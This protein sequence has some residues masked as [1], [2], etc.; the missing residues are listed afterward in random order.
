MFQRRL[1]LL[2]PIGGL[3]VLALV[4]ILIS[5]WQSF[6]TSKPEPATSKR[7]VIE[8]PPDQ[9]YGGTSSGSQL[10]ISPDGKTIV[11]LARGQGNR[12]LYVKNI[13]DD[14]PATPIPGTER[15]TEPT[16]S[17]MGEQIAFVSN[18]RIKTVSAQGGPVRDAGEAP[19]IRG[20]SWLSDDELVLGNGRGGLLRFKLS[21]GISSALRKSDGEFGP[22]TP[23]Y[24]PHVLPG[25]KAV[26]FTAIDGFGLRSA[27]TRVL[28]LETGEVRTVISDSGYW[29]RYA[30]SG[31]IVYASE[32]PHVAMA[33]HFDLD[34]LKVIGLP[35]RIIDIDLG[36]GYAGG[37]D[38]VFSASGVMVYAPRSPSDVDELISNLGGF[39]LSQIHVVR[40]WFED[41]TQKLGPA[42]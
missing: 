3:V 41:L 37:T 38:F 9:A 6:M 21:E 11:Y 1:L 31:H 39:N 2:V 32:R 29:A 5:V 33:A 35:Q 28:L 25:G 27:R 34:E 7:L 16:F 18:S 23:T 13:G 12:V 4:A 8:I 17:P 24:W 19:M 22:E 30:P 40:N 14:V 26:L 10:D 20:V 42:S 15:A 36:G